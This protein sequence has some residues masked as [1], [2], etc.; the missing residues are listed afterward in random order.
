MLCLLVGPQGSHSH[1]VTFL[2]QWGRTKVHLVIW[3]LCEGCRTVVYMTAGYS[4]RL[5]FYRASWC[6]GTSIRQTCTTVRR[7]VAVLTRRFCHHRKS[8]VTSHLP[9]IGHVQRS[10]N[11]SP[12]SCTSSMV[13]TLIVPLGILLALLQ[14]LPSPVILRSKYWNQM[15]VCLN[16]W[17]GSVR[18]AAGDSAGW[19][20]IH[21]YHS[22]S[23]Q[24]CLWIVQL[25]WLLNLQRS[26]P[27]RI[28]EFAV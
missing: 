3:L 16:V 21:R 19:W 5:G 25:M 4:L 22:F 12:Q 1:G 26:K 28:F 14:L 20:M 10:D 27:F 11:H 8:S 24:T 17:Y 13:L 9:V 6:S 15:P 23:L 18:E 2:I 7:D